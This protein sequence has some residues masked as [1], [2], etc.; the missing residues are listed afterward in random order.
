M[1]K[2][3]N[4]LG[5]ALGGGGAWGL[6]HIGVL[7]VLERRGLRPNLIVGTSMGAVIGAMY[8]HWRSAAVLES[9][10]R[11]C[12]L[13]PAVRNLGLDKLTT[14]PQTGPRFLRTVNQLA[15]LSLL[16]PALT[17]SHVVAERRIQHLL[18][19]LIPHVNIEQLPMRFAAVATDITHG[20]P[21]ILAHGD[22]PSAV[23]ASSAIPG[24][25]PPVVRYGRQLIDGCLVALVPVPEARSL[26]AKRIIAVDVTKMPAAPRTYT[27]GVDIC[28]R[29]GQIALLRMRD[30]QCNQAETSILVNNILVD[31]MAFHRL[32]ELVTAGEQAAE[33]AL[34]NVN[35]PTES[36]QAWRNA[37][38]WWPRRPARTPAFSRSSPA[39]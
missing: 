33:R 24:I 17:K 11:E 3:N 16:T 14:A 39:A 23:Q 9:R 1:N 29:A 35:F 36:D 10:L 21:H 25:F 30:Q 5:L 26:G 37:P 19:L 18:S 13:T 34:A 2:K 12:L 27:T 7:K 38:T 31:W 8:C 4:S 6:A 20:V 15:R 28:L 22:L 32:D